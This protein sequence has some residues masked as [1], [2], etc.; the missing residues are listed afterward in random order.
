[1]VAFGEAARKE[2]YPAGHEERPYYNRRGH[3]PGSDF[4]CDAESLA[5][6]R[7]QGFQF[8]VEDAFFNAE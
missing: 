5:S 8:A 7:R 1:M 2:L 4:V 3:L 6:V